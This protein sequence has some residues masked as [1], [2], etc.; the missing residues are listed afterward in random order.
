MGRVDWGVAVTV[1]RL[2]LV[3]IL[4]CLACSKKAEPARRTQ[5][6]LAHPSASADA[7]VSGARLTFHFVTGSS[8]RFSVPGRKAKVSGRVPLADGTLQLNPRDLKSASARVDVDLGQ[9][10]IEEDALP[11]GLELGGS[12]PTALAL[13]WLELGPEVA[14][15]RRSAVSKARFELTG[16]DALS[17]PLLDFGATRTNTQVRA[18]AVGT[19]LIHGFRAPVRVELLLAPLST[20]PG[21]PRR[22]SIRSASALVLALAPHD[23]TARGPSGIFDALGAARAA[24]WI[25]KN[26]RVEFDLVAEAESTPN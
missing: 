12:T 25:G 13:Q 7:E 18:T 10:T 3:A 24:A 20:E 4:C 8:V 22:L 17:A 9:L 6:W 2:A 15:E 5:P 11:E 21:A 26:A 23:I 1:A 14:P 16:I 19:L